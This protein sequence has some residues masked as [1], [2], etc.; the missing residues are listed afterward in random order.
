MEKWPKTKKLKDYLTWISR[1]HPLWMDLGLERIRCVAERLNL[2]HPSAPVIT[3]TGTNGKGSCIAGLE[4]IYLTVGLK[5]GVFQSPA[6]FKINEEIRLDGKDVS[7]SDLEKSF[8]QIHALQGEI[9]LT[10]F[11]YMTLAALILFK[12]AAV[13]LIILEV[14]LGGRLDAVNIVDAEMAI[15]SSIALDHQAFLGET[16]AKIALEKS[17]I[18]RPGK[19]VICGDRNPPKALI[20][21]AKAMH[22]PFYQVE[23]NAL[24]DNTA[25]VLKAI[26]VWQEK[27]P[28]SEAQCREGL[29]RVFL[30]GRLQ[31]I[32]HPTA[33]ITEVFDV[34]HNPAAIKRL[35]K[36]LSIQPMGTQAVFSMLKDK[37]ITGCLRLMKSHIKFWHVA[38]ISTEKTYRAASLPEL[39]A[40]FQAAEIP[41]EKIRMYPDLASAYEGAWNQRELPLKRLVIFGSFYTISSTS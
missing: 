28:V 5:V 32:Y 31:E 1:S 19:P 12:Q 17:G 3:V 2:L 34:A 21:K 25:T 11:E 35:V 8:S 36:K 15:V 6:L 40:A 37:D 33:D 9:S 39:L 7:D 4:Q 24:E 30:P 27:F 29:S 26:E 22:C 38:T 23:S 13:D 18:F 41:K 20:K 10:L 14:G 16:R